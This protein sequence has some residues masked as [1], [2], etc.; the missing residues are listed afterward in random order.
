[1]LQHKGRTQNVMQTR[2]LQADMHSHFPWRVRAGLRA[3]VRQ[4]LHQDALDVK[5]DS[6][7]VG[8]AVALVDAIKALGELDEAHG[9]P[10]DGV[11]EE[12]EGLQRRAA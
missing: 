3:R 11:Q 6:V 1:M 4:Q 2:P 10:M 7:A 8:I 9:T 12:A 5:E